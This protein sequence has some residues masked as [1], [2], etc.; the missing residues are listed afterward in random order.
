MAVRSSTKYSWHLLYTSSTS[1]YMIHLY[2]QV[3]TPV[4]LQKGSFSHHTCVKLLSYSCSSNTMQPSRLLYLLQS[5]KDPLLLLFF[6]KE[7][8][9][10]SRISNKYTKVHKQTKIKDISRLRQKVLPQEDKR[11]LPRR[12]PNR[13]LSIRLQPAP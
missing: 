4:F 12:A 1:Y 6:P 3:T 2:G 5:T 13:R 10:A 8:L 7:T 9:P 11:A